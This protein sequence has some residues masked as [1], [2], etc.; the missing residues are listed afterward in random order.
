MLTAVPK[1]RHLDEFADAVDRTEHDPAVRYRR[2]TRSLGVT[3]K[4]IR[5]QAKAR[6]W[7][8]TPCYKE[9][10]EP[11]LIKW[12]N[13]KGLSAKD[14][15]ALIRLVPDIEFVDRDDMMSLYRTAFSEQVC[16]WLMDQLGLDFRRRRAETRKDL[17]EGLA[18]TW[19]CPVT[20]SLDISQF[21]HVNGITNRDHR[22]QWRALT[23]FGDLAAVADYIRSESIERIVLVEDFVGSGRQ[24]CEA[25]KPVLEKGTVQIPAL[26]VPLMVSDSGLTKLRGLFAPH[27]NWTVAPSVVI[28]RT[29]QVRRD[30]CEDEP[31]FIGETRS[32][33]LRTEHRFAGNAFGYGGVG[34][35]IVLHTN[36]PNNTPPLLRSREN[37]WKPLFPRVSRAKK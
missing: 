4:E 1:I 2:E 23:Q 5:F 11:R 14:Q 31:S 25:L 30:S 20:D 24:C 28:P 29:V 18:R 37:N 27:P 22:P 7:Q 26:L 16:R 12:L 15:A 21:Y 13:N 6:Y 33:I 35:L 17:R 19:I 10:F 9:E 32:V 3:L 36:C 34:A 8:F